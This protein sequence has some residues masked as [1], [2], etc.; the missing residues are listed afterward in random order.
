MPVIEGYRFAVSLEDRGLRSGLN[1][2]K[3]E[4][5]ELKSV[6]RANFTTLSQGEG[7]LAAFNRRIK[8][9]QNTIDTYKE[10]I[11]SLNRQIKTNQNNLANGAGD[12]LKLNR[13][14]ARDKNTIASYTRQLTLLKAQQERDAEAAKR[15]ASGID[16]LRKA[17]EDVTKS[18]KSYSL[19]LQNQGRYYASDRA[20]INGLKKARSALSSQMQAEGRV[21]AQLRSQVTRLRGNEAEQRNSLTRSISKAKDLQSTY[22]KLV[23]TYGKN[24][25]V[26]KQNRAEYARLKDSIQAQEGALQGTSERMSKVSQAYTNQADKLRTVAGR[27]RQV[28][29]AAGSFSNSRVASVYRGLSHINSEVKNSFSNTREWASSLKGAFATVAAG[30]GVAAA[31]I[32]K[33]VS[34][35]AKVQRQYIE[36]RNLLETS[37]EHTSTAIRHMNQMQRDGV[38]YSEKYG[39]AQQQI[40]KEYEDLA[41]RGYSGTAALGSMNA[42][43][44]ASRASGDSLDDVVRSVAQSVDAFGMRSNHAATMMHNTE[45]AANAMASAADR[46]AAGFQDMGVAMG[47]VSGSAHNAG[48]SI[49]QTSAAVGE[50]SNKGLEGTRAG[51]GLRKVITSLVKPTANAQKALKSAGLSVSDLVG[52]SGKLKS[53]NQIFNLIDK[54]TAGWGGA[55][56]GRF[57]NMIFGSTGQEAAQFLADSAKGLNANNSALAKLTRNVEK[58]ERTDYIGRLAKKNMQS[59]QMQIQRLQKTAQAFEL[60]VGARVLPAVNKVGN[61]IAKWAVSREGRRSMNQF[62]DAIGK[63]AMTIA[64]HTQDVIAF[65]RGLYQGLHAS[66]EVAK[67]M[68]KPINNVLSA[69]HMSSRS[70]QGFA[71]TLGR[72]VGIFGSITLGVKAFRTLFGGVVAIAKDGSGIFDK[73]RGHIFNSSSATKSLNNQLKEQVALTQDVLKSQQGITRE[74]QRQGAVSEVESKSGGNSTASDLA[75]NLDFGESTHGQTRMGRKWA[76]SAN[77]VAKQA[78]EEADVASR[79]F[80]NRLAYGLRHPIKFKWRTLFHPGE[81]AALAS[82]AKSGTGFATRMGQKMLNSHGRVKFRALFKY[83]EQAAEAG[84]GASGLSFARSM[85]MHIGNG[86]NRISRGVKSL[87]SFIPGI[88]V[89][90]G[91][92]SGA[93]MMSKMVD[94]V[95]KW[96]GKVTGVVTAISGGIDLVKGLREH[97]ST[98][99]MR[100]FGSAG[101]MAAGAGIG[102]ALGSVVP[103]AG[104]AAGAALG[105]SLGSSIGKHLPEMI[106]WGK[107]LIHAFGKGWHNG[108]RWFHQLITGDWKGVQKGFNNFNNGM[109]SWFD[110]TFDVNGKG[111]SHKTT[112]HRTTISDR[113][114]NTGVHVKKRD[115]ANV[116]AMS[117]ALKAY[118]SSLKRV[119]AQMRRY[120][121]SSQLNKVNKFLVAH[122]KSWKETAKPIRQIG[123]AFKYLSKFAGAVAKKDAFA[124]FNRDLPRMDR[125]LRSHGDSIKKGLKELTKALKGGSGKNTL[126]AQF[127]KMDTAITKIEKRFK[128]LNKYLDDTAKDFKTLAKAFS[129]FTK[130]KNPL[131]NMASGMDKLKKA[132]NND[133]KSISANIKKLISALVA[134]GK[135]GHSLSGALTSINKP[136]TS[137]SKAF[138]SMNKT[139]T[140]VQRSLTKI[141]QA[142]KTLAGGGTTLLTKFSRGFNTLKRTLTN[143]SRSIVHNLNSINASLGGTGKKKRGLTS[144]LKS[145]VTSFTKFSKRAK[146]TVRSLRSLSGSLRTIVNRLRTLAS[147][148]RGIPSVTRALNK[149][150]RSSKANKF[151]SH[152][153][154]QAKKA[155]AA[156]EGKSNFAEAFRKT[157]NKMISEERRLNADT[158][159]LWSTMFKKLREQQNSWEKK[160]LSSQSSFNKKWETGWSHVGTGVEHIFAR[161]WSNMRNQAGHGMNKVLSILNA[162]I[163][164]INRVITRF[165]GNGGAVGHVGYVHY[166]TGTGA[167][168]NAVRRPITKPTLAMLNDGNDSPQTHNEEAVLNKRTGDVTVYHGQNIMKMLTPDNEVFNAT[169]SR[170]LGF[171]HYATGTGGGLKA[172]YELAKKFWK[173]PTQTLKLE[174]TGNGLNQLRGALNGLGKGMFD[175]AR[176]Q[177]DTWWTQLWKMVEDK[178]EDGGGPAAGL[179]KAVEKYG[180][181]HRYVWGASGPS[182]FDCSGLVMYA[183]NKAYGIQYPH[184][185]GA[186]YARS[187]HISRSQARMGDLVFWGR[188][189]SE[190][191]GVYAGGNRYFS[192]Q[193]PSQGIHMNTLDSVVGKGAPLFARV[194]GANTHGEADSKIKAKTGLQ[195]Y[196]RN[197]VGKG[198]WKTIAKIAEKYGDANYGGN[199][200]TEGMVE[201][202]ARR[203]HVHLPEGFAKDVIRVA[204]SESGNRNV[205]QHVKDMNSGWN[206]AQGPLQFTPQTFKAFAMPGHTNIHNPYDE[207]L[208]FFNNSDWRNSIGWTTIW[209]QR[210]FDWLHSGPQGHRRFANGGLANKP[211]IFGEQGL[212]M[213]IP[214]SPSKQ[215]RALDLLAQTVAIMQANQ[216]G[217]QTQSA[218]EQAQEK[219]NNKFK[220]ELI[221]L[222]QRISASSN[223][224][225]QI[226]VNLDGRQIATSL[227]P[228]MR[229][230]QRQ[231][232]IFGRKGFSNGI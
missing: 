167:F 204:M 213:A 139:V 75:S 146:S 26:V 15:A 19:A 118:A 108:M 11:D 126:V 192:A 128:A 137:V 175:K 196:I 142:V 30:A 61:Q 34:D 174:I 50:L 90:T 49:E 116:K 35:A 149:L 147:K 113:V 47:Y 164:R 23:T 29:Q 158:Q 207:L 165:G 79:S 88:S 229:N 188:G 32:T 5:R 225:V 14:I 48:W 209:H 143:D 1:A 138:K 187:E 197:Q 57:F 21:T 53:I 226:N 86:K 28:S 133:V 162:G 84:G 39:F 78:R 83:G 179:L 60:T 82:G 59:G 217:S 76:S 17:T 176:D 97:N 107:K 215:P 200:I 173:H 65:G 99:K 43:M 171:T 231:D 117:H 186:Q 110:K 18:S 36:V 166:A 41:R 170:E 101:G 205:K 208:A 114:I 168:A 42:M 66:Y 154:S 211:S 131:T 3:T 38:A 122:T 102:A 150:G 178:V 198:F 105:A 64:N 210:K 93:G 85:A 89:E 148:S 24:S 54:S 199:T 103:G 228:L 134:K 194:R 27:Y 123:D 156:F 206:D 70:S 160:T 152:I 145:A 33:A 232:I 125:T 9:S 193:S 46:T 67:A 12:A 51:T 109:A 224:N 189:G 91:A 141:S 25:D 100:D 190:H 219:A 185:S 203:M 62:G 16:V 151:G 181:G 130:S 195:K 13:Q 71:T 94:V 96:G 191:V 135:G 201:A 72:I 121:P 124:A 69:F 81:T 74:M 129:E 22:N 227:Q 216:G 87:L 20:R 73:I 52:K 157:A 77:E 92:T 119:T 8:D 56:K 180:E 127:N 218:Q 98:Q 172:L 177:A 159:K 155:S 212:E 136:L 31:G 214:L 106:A 184:F 10:A 161:F 202:A 37:G 55:R 40:A 111:E 221:A 7:S 153:A 6:M 45:R 220:N 95:G 169:E 120:N 223:G 58:D 2:I 80:H 144:S 63:I 140:P 115:V 230:Q 44:K 163:T 104:T 4:A 182:T 222:L 68:L 132:L 183:L 112:R